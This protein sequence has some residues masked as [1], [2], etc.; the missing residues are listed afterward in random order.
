MTKKVEILKCIFTL[1]YAVMLINTA[2][3]PTLEI[4]K[5]LLF[6]KYNLAFIDTKFPSFSSGIS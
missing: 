5:F 3:D 1:H 6:S 4:L 2:F